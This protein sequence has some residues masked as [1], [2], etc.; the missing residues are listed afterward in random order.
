MD[1][2]LFYPVSYTHLTGALYDLLPLIPAVVLLRALLL[3][4]R[5]MQGG[6]ISVLHE[7]CAA[8]FMLYLLALFSQTVALHTLVTRGFSFSGS[9]NVIPFDFVRQ[10]LSDG[11]SE[12]LLVNVFGNILMFVPFGL[13]LP[14]GWGPFRRGARTCLAGTLASL[15]IEFLQAFCGRSTDIDDVLLNTL[16]TLL[17]YAL[18]A[19]ARRLWPRF[20]T[21][22]LCGASGRARMH[23][24]AEPPPELPA[25]EK[26]AAS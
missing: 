13:L 21:K 1:T 15:L 5:K 10:G 19:A 12:H 25:A 24:A 17:G 3:A 9:W 14:L 20:C 18:F 2:L 23:A 6:R 8:V 16:G 4:A 11:V 22:C 7:I 26:R